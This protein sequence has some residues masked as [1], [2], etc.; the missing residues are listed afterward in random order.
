MSTSVN[1]HEL[2]SKQGGTQ[3]PLIDGIEQGFSALHLNNPLARMAVAGGVVLA[4]EALLFPEWVRDDNGKFRNWR[5]SKWWI[6]PLAGGL[7][8]GFF[9]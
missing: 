5:E 4:G 9:I 7:L 8:C 6:G 2:L 1:I 3:F